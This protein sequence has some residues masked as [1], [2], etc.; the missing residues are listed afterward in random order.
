MSNT[1]WNGNGKFQDLAD[2]LTGQIPMTGEAK[3]RHIE[4]LRKAVNAYYDVYNNG[5]CNRGHS[6]GKHF[7]GVMKILNNRWGPTD[8]DTVERITEPKMDEIILKVA[9]GKG[10]IDD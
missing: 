8:W 5:G 2:K 7:P 9:K 4:R 6:I 3:D 1:Y 10:L